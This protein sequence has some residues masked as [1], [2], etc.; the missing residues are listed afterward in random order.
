MTPRSRSL[1]VAM[2][3]KPLDR[4][5]LVAELRDRQRLLRQDRDQACPARRPACGSAPR[6]GRW[7]RSPHRPHHRALDQRLPRRP[8]GQQPGVVPA[9]ADRFLGGA[10]GALHEQGRVAGDGRGAGART[11]RS[12]RCRARRAA[13]AP[14]RWRGWRPP[15]PSSRRGPTYFGVITVPSASRRAGRSRT[16]HGDRRQPGGRGRSSL[17][18]SAA[19]SSAYNCSACGRNVALVDRLDVVAWA[20]VVDPAAGVTVLVT[21]TP[22]ASGGGG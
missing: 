13:A 15:P 3:L 6:P 20:T 7:C 16:A 5:H 18:A 17:A 21:R 14:G 4:L 12:W 2:R 8:L 9:V 22:G 10:G 1:A 19:N 11:P